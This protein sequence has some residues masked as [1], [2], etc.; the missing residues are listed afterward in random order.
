MDS[1][2]LKQIKSKREF[3]QLR[4]IDIEKNFDLFSKRQAT[5][6]EKID[7]TKERLRK[8]FTAFLSKKLLSFKDKPA[9]WILRKHI[10][11]NERLPYY[12]ELYNRIL[13]DKKEVRIFDLG[14]GINGFSYN[15]FPSKV[16]Y[17]GFESVGQLVEITNSFFEKNKLPAKCYHLSL[18][19][20]NEIIKIIKES[21]GNKIIFLFKVI[22][23]LE[24]VELDYSKKLLLSLMG[25]V[26]EIVLSFSTKSLGKKTNFKAD[27]KWIL[28]FVSKNFHILDNFEIGGER[29]LVFTRRIFK[30]SKS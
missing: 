28:E 25:D 16:N 29:Y 13:K 21:K 18:F 23:A 20:L 30:N 6:Q 14:C 2:I 1:T 10:S 15:Y 19:E 11:T 3:S 5:E 24:S 26:D 22:D 8:S 12:K 17:S 7:L 9:D 27:R 4:E